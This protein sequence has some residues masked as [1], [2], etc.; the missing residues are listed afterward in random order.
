MN[1]T[2]RRFSGSFKTKVVL[3]ALKERD[4]IQALS[5]RFELHPIISLSGRGNFWRMQTRPSLTKVRKT[6]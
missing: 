2:R 1:R 5:A 3:E 6:R 4:T